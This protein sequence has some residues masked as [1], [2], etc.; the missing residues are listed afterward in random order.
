MKNCWTNVLL[1]RIV[2]PFFFFSDVILK[3]GQTSACVHGAS[4]RTYGGKKRLWALRVRLPPLLALQ[5]PLTWLFPY[6]FSLQWIP[7]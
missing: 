3:V 4:I 1:G 6:K 2:V 5:P 7:L